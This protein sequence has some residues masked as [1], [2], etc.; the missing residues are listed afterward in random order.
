M[1]EK[2]SLQTSIRNE[3]RTTMLTLGLPRFEADTAK[4]YVVL[5]ALVL[6]GLLFLVNTSTTPAARV[7]S[8]P[9][10]SFAPGTPEAE[11][12][13]DRALQDV[14]TRS[15]MNES[16]ALLDNAKLAPAIDETRIGLLQ[17]TPY[18]SYRG[19][20]HEEVENREGQVLQDLVPADRYAY[21]GHPDVKIQALMA[22]RKFVNEYDRSLREEYVRQFLE[23]AR[24]EGYAIQLN[25]QLEVVR[26][27]RLPKHNPLNLP[28]RRGASVPSPS[29]SP[30]ESGYSGS[31]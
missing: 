1:R 22:R 4:Q 7:A 24:R 26:V 8:K 31:R 10:A 12:Y 2:T 15:E 5:I 29:R 16:R 14:A 20:P 3:E 30:L 18:D 28:S 23:N 21:E 9:K 11:L 6:L 25:D 19:F 17:R 27:Q 13:M